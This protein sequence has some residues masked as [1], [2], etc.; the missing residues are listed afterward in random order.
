MIAR[1][2]IARLAGTA[3]LVGGV[4]AMQLGQGAP[5]TAASTKHKTVKIVEKNDNY[6]FNPKKL[7]IKRG[8]TVIWKNS[9]DAPHTVTGK[10][11]W[12]HNTKTFSDGKSVK[13]TFKKAGTYKYYCAVHPY[14][15]AKIIVK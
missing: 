1:H 13:F 5:A 9:T 7:T 15:T 4:A 11:S 8:T 2:R 3:L 6:G 12:K 10:G 14:M